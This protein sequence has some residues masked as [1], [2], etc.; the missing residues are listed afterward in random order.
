MKAIVESVLLNQEVMS[1]KIF[2]EILTDITSCKNEEELRACMGM[3]EKRYTFL[4]KY[5]KYGFGRNHMWVCEA[6]RKERLL[7]VEF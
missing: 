3:I 6:G 1:L 5:F 7:F 4:D 2:M